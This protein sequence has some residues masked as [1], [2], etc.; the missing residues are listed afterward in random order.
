MNVIFS[1]IFS[2]ETEKK[3]EL[4]IEHYLRDEELVDDAA[5]S[6]VDGDFVRRD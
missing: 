3:E 1:A 4:Q 6:V 5:L 2:G